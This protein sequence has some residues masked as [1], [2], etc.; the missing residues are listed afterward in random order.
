MRS[1]QYLLFITYRSSLICHRIT[2]MI[3]T[4]YGD[5][6]LSYPCHKCR[7]NITHNFLRVAKFRKDT[8][9]LIM[10]DWPLGGTIITPTTGTPVAPSERIWHWEPN[11]FPNR[12]VGKELRVRILEL[13]SPGSTNEPTMN[14]VKGILES[15]IRDRSVIKKVNKG[16]PVESGILV[17]REKLAIRKMMSRYWENTSIFALELGGAVIRQG[18]FVEKM[19]SIDWLHSPTAKSTMERLITKYARFMQIIAD[20]PFHVAVPTLDVDLGW[21]THQLSP[22]AYFNYTVDKCRKFIDHDDKIDEDELSTSFEW[23]SKTYQKQYKEVYS[24]CT[25]WYCEGMFPFIYTPYNI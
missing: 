6:G 7:S 15:A 4:G 18:V 8:E 11:L 13:I 23:T 12:L 2:Q 25:C 14:D 21:H 20:H 24:E 3:G 22:Q 1:E 9:N 17:G 19:H 5:R 16:A 10:K